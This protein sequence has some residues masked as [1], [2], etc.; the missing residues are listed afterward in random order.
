MRNVK[1][2]LFGAAKFHIWREFEFCLFSGCSRKIVSFLIKL[3]HILT[4]NVA[5]G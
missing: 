3:L 5:C 4:K 1:E 2:V